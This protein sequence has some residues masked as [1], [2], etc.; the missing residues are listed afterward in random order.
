[1]ARK[2]AQQLLDIE[3]ALRAAAKRLDLLMKPDDDP[4]KLPDSVDEE[5]YAVHDA[6]L[7][8]A[9]QVRMIAQPII[10]RKGR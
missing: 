2:D 4:A 9:D 3:T 1:M 7:E 10:V 5:L 6:I 8:Q